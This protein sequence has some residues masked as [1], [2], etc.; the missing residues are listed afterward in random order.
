MK[1]H[2]EIKVDLMSKEP[3]EQVIT[4]D[5]IF[6]FSFCVLSIFTLSFILAIKLFFFT[7][8]KKLQIFKSR[9]L[10]KKNKRKDFYQLGTRNLMEN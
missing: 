8:W 5:T 3:F 2:E 9:E 7:N 6:F 1:Y 10:G 4:H